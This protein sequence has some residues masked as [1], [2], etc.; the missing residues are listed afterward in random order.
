LTDEQ[1]ADSIGAM[2]PK[3]IVFIALLLTCGSALAANP[4]VG[5]WKLD[6]AKS[7][8]DRGMGKNTTVVYA[9][10]GNKIK[11]TVDGVDAKGKPAHNEWVGKFDGKDYPITGDQTFDT[12]AYKQVNDRTLAMTLK[13][14]G[15]VLGGGQ[16]EVSRDG[17]TR[18]VTLDTVM[19]G[20]KTHNVAVYDKM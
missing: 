5:T 12:R 4:F 14:G 18:T 7:K 11:V 9:R 16:V 6:E 15:K 20:R 3:A 13:K 10:E 19:K 8:L 1:I 17:K 2:K